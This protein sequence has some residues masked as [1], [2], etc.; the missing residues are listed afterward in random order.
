MHAQA[1]RTAAEW[2]SR[3]HATPTPWR[4]TRIHHIPHTNHITNT[5]SHDH[6]NLSHALQPSTFAGVAHRSGITGPERGP[7]PEQGAA[8]LT[9]HDWE[10]GGSGYEHL[11]GS[12]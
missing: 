11:V 4:R 5:H 3:R 7:V 12:T 6:T 8:P 9:Y 1:Q 2:H 10:H